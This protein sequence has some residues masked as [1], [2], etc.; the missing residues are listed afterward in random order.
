[1]TEALFRRTGFRPAL[2]KSSPTIQFTPDLDLLRSVRFLPLL[3]SRGCPYRCV[4]CASRII[5]PM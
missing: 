5:Q 2:D 4:Y 3:T 1:M